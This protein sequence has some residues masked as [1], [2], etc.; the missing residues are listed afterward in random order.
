MCL[1]FYLPKVN[2]YLMFLRFYL[3]KVNFYLMLWFYIPKVNFYLMLGKSKPVEGKKQPIG[4]TYDVRAGT[5]ART[6]GRALGPGP[7]F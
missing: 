5:Q 3:P 6:Q 7:F 4:R 2:F 1:R